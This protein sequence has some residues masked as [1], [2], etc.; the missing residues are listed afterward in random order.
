MTPQ[1]FAERL[2]QGGPNLKKDIGNVLLS[3][4]FKIQAG[5]ARNFT[6]DDLPEY[7]RVKDTSNTRTGGKPGTQYS[8]YLVYEDGEKPKAFKS[9]MSGFNVGPRSITGNLRRS[10]FTKLGEK[11]GNPA[12][13]ITAGVKDPL[14][15]A[16]AIEFGS[17]DR[18]ILPRF[19]IGR[20][21]KEVNES[22]AKRDLLKHLHTALGGE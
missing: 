3:L 9:G 2:R 18:N 17:P 10:L 21:F 19:Y 5:A 6:E 1:E 13:F 14:P 12:V 11:D 4:G 22:E 15:Y 7:T 20:A 16:A 8:S